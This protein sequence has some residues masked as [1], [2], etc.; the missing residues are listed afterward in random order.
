MSD[1]PQT[2]KLPWLLP[3]LTGLVIAGVAEPFLLQLLVFP[4]PAGMTV[5]FTSP[6]AFTITLLPILLLTFWWSLYFA[7]F[8]IPTF[9]I[10]RHCR[11]NRAVHFVLVET[12]FITSALFQTTH[13]LV[14]MLIAALCGV[15]FLVFRYLASKLS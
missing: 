13:V 14:N 9:I 12:S 2:P 3:T 4:H 7:A 8:L 1:F 5:A 6:I 15:V 11:L 10:E